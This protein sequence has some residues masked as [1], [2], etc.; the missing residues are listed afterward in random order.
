MDPLNLPESICREFIH[1]VGIADTPITL[2]DRAFTCSRKSA[3]RF[4]LARRLRAEGSLFRRFGG[5]SHDCPESAQFGNYPLGRLTRYPENGSVNAASG[6][7]ADYTSTGY[8][9]IGKRAE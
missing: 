7:Q 8:I 3:D 9:P 5:S 1:R 6:R 4:E 2:Q